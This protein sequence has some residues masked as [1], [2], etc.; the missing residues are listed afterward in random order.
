[1]RLERI[2]KGERLTGRAMP[3]RLLTGE[4]FLLIY[5]YAICKKDSGKNLTDTE[6]YD[7]ISVLVSVG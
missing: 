6:S 7:K 5:L 1:M 2:L 3:C 4:G